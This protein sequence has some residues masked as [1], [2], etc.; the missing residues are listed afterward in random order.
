MTSNHNGVLI[1][2]EMSHQNSGGFTTLANWLNS[3][4]FGRC[5]V[6]NQTDLFCPAFK[7]ANTFHLSRAD[8]Y[9]AKSH[10]ATL[11]RWLSFLT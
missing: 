9:W 5:Q 6:K 3:K 2:N 4:G 1:W 10:H 8:P 7:E 11:G